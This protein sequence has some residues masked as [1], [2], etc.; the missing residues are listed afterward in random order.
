MY[1]ASSPKDAFIKHIMSSW[2][3]SRKEV[4]RSEAEAE[5]KSGRVRK[6]SSHEWVLGDYEIK[7]VR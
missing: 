2:G 6:I 7:K 5:Q 3:V 4:M 1:L